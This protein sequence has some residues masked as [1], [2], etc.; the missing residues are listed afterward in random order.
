M[1]VLK[2][3]VVKIMSTL[4]KIFPPTSFDVMI[5]LVIHLVEELEVCGLVHTRWMY[6]ME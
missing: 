6:P 5:H 3:K 2:V 1:Q 4:K